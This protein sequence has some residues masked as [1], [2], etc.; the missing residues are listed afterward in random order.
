MHAYRLQITMFTDRCLQS[1]AVTRSV[2]RVIRSGSTR[3]RRSYSMTGRTA[4]PRT[5]TRPRWRATRWWSTWDDASLAGGQPSALPTTMAHA[6]NTPKTPKKKRA[7]RMAIIITH[8][9]T[10][11][12]HSNLPIKNTVSSHTHTHTHSLSL[13]LSLSLRARAHTQHSSQRSRISQRRRGSRGFHE[14][15]NLS[16]GSLWA[17]DPTG[18]IRRPEI[19]KFSRL[20][21]CV[22][23]HITMRIGHGVHIGRGRGRGRGVGEDAATIGDTEKFRKFDN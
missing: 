1:D 10:T 8:G 15:G 5:P 23:C 22:M 18:R 4:P 17:P 19:N 9:A 16:Y 2:C 11:L 21:A 7:A 20:T 6:K 14:D 3:R 12:Q 13:S